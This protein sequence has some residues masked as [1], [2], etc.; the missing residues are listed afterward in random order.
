MNIRILAC[1]ISTLDYSQ[2]EE[3][4]GISSPQLKKYKINGIKW[5]N[6][7]NERYEFAEEFLD[8]C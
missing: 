1:K 3:L 4:V 5:E 6:R 2:R 8:V 7:H